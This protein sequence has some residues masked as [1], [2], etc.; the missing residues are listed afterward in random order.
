MPRQLCPRLSLGRQTQVIAL[1]CLD[2]KLRQRSLR[3]LSKICKA[4][5]IVPTS[6]I[7]QQ[8]LIRIG[9]VCYRSGFADVSDGEYLGC[10]VAIKRLK[11]VEDSDR[12][13]KV[14]IYNQ[15]R[16]LPPLS[17]PQ[18]LCREIIGWKHMSHPNI[19]PLLGVSV[20]TDSRRFW[21]ITEWMPNGNVMQYV[22][23]NPEANR[24]RLVWL[25]STPLNFPYSSVAF[26]SLTSRL[27]WPTSTNSVLFMETSKGQVRHS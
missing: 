25:F 26:S 8:D 16:A 22:R 11:M 14:L 9:R 4:R 19:L 17:F 20:S 12:T 27:V 6:Y 24:L 1:S 7:L 23:S 2:G 21:I 3:L 13:F 10:T 18:R 15:S 5:R